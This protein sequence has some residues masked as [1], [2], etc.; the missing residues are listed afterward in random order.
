MQT[1]GRWGKPLP[2]REPQPH[3]PLVAPRFSKERAGVR[4][5]RA[6]GCQVAEYAGRDGS[7]LTPLAPSCLTPAPALGPAWWG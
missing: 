1:C 6:R 2:K 3:A 7:L 5:P 4:R